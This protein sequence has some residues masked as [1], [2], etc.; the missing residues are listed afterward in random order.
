M[1]IS[2]FVTLCSQYDKSKRIKYQKME[3]LKY[4]RIVVPLCLCVLL[5]LF[6][7]KNVSFVF[8]CIC[9]NDR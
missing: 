2:M 3:I 5:C 7:K 9:I 6:K 8:I 4:V 1:D